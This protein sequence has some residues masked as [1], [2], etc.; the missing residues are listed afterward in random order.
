MQ[1]GPRFSRLVK[2][3]S[4]MLRRMRRLVCLDG[5]RGRARVLR[6]AQ[7]HAAVPPLPRWLHWLFRHGGAGVDVF[8]ILSGLVI[9]QSLA[10]FEYRRR[11]FLIARVARIYP[12]F[13]VVFLSRGG[14][15]AAGDWFDGHGLDRAGK[16]GAIH[17]VGW[18]AD[19]LGH[20]DRHPSGND[21]RAVSRRR[22]ARTSWVAFL[23]AA[24]SLSTEWQFYMLALLI[25]QPLGLR[26][27]GLAVSG[28][29]RRPRS[30]GRWRVPQRGSSAARSCRT[31]HSI[32]PSASQRDRGPGGPGALPLYLTVLVAAC[33][34]CPRC[35]AA[36]RSCWRPCYGQCA[37]QPSMN[38]LAADGRHSR[39]CRCRGQADFGWLPRCWQGAA[40]ASRCGSGAVSY[41]IY[42]VNEPV[43]NC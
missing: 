28:D 23:G 25:A 26:A 20:G 41:C 42:L 29:R 14:G 12:V 8:F 31:R 33:W 27:D 30:P 38:V 36:L 9:V 32:S 34:R 21:P 7:P 16:R 35:K 2:P 15:A 5:L 13:L 39:P 1:A 43:Q 37:W 17:L 6:H 19:R 10:S 24:W 11:P 3:P 4:A 18:L 40:V 22:S